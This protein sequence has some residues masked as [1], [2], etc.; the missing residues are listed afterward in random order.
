M[1]I[2]IKKFD[3]GRFEITVTNFEKS[4]QSPR[5]T[6]V[7]DPLSYDSRA[8]GITEVT[9]D[10]SPSRHGLNWKLKEDL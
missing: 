5:I 10:F 8:V 4:W 1:L 3:Y 6:P 7:A 9:L 2:N